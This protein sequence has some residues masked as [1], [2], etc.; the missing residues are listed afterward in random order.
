MHRITTYRE[1]WPFYL[2]EHA[3]AETRF[4]HMA[5]TGLAVVFLV[6]AILTW[7]V[8]LL[9]AALVAGYGP[10]WLTHFTIEK[11][12]PATFRYPIWS[13]ISDFRMAATWLS[14]G[15]SRELEKAGIKT[16]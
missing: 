9:L 15:L 7:N 6:A 3:K 12:R 1:F 8:W 5:G 4:W 16:R 11:N 10:A 14:G 2:S 13:L